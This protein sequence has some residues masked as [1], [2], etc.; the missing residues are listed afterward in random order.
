MHLP[1]LG[2]TLGSLPARHLRLQG[3]IHAVLGDDVGDLPLR[4]AAAAQTRRWVRVGGPHGL[5][6]RVS[7]TPA[8]VFL[9]REV[10]CR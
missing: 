6:L 10:R 7:T 3:R 2:W 1:F 5:Q 4:G 9:G 8:G